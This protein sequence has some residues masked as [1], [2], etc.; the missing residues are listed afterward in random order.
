MKGLPVVKEHYA[1]REVFP[2]APLALVAAE[3]RFA[4][5]PRIKEEDIRD[6]FAKAVR[7]HLPI[8][9]NEFIQDLNNPQNQPTSEEPRLPQIRAMNQTSTISVSLNP[10]AILF[11]AVEYKRFED[12]MSLIKVGLQALDKL[13]PELFINRI[14]LRY[15]DELRMPN[16]TNETRDWSQWVHDDLLAPLSALPN[17]RGA[18]TSGATVY[19][20]EDSRTVVFR[21]GSLFGPTLLSSD[22]ALRRAPHEPGHIF[23]LDID[24]FNQLKEQIP[25]DGEWIIQQFEQ[26]H[27]PT[28]TIFNWATSENAKKF[29]RGEA[30]V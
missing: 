13:L 5:E 17:S 27:I 29:F 22:M 15:V 12:L 23:I 14:G 8:L 10:N 19:E 20:I 28:G 26:L 11:E 1:H 18:A 4:Y 25:F 30:N 3:V 6:S 24:A 7:S 2:N 9:T 21:W 16:L